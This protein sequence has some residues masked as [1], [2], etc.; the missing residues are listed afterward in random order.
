M[1]LQRLAASKLST[2]V[3]FST[4]VVPEAWTIISHVQRN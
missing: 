1:F 4:S 3:Q 2:G